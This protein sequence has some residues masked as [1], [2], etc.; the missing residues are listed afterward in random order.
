MN[1]S[2]TPDKIYL[3]PDAYREER[4]T[5]SWVQGGRP[6]VVALPNFGVDLEK[7]VKT[8]ILGERYEAGDNV[9][10][11]ATDTGVTAETIDGVITISVPSQVELYGIYV[12]GSS[13]ILDE[14]SK[15]TININ[16]LWNNRANI[17]KTGLTYG[18]IS[19]WE[20]DSAEPS[21][22]IVYRQI[23]TDPPERRIIAVGDNAFTYEFTTMNLFPYWAISIS[24]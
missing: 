23:L 1:R 10:V 13:D 6:T 8:K 9:W 11:F 19:I 22:I 7:W 2:R 16:Y 17:D 15:I 5:S 21:S 18:H 14:D 3:L 20:T 12:V 24:I 4:T